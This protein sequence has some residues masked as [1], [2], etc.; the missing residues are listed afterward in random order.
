MINT[1]REGEP[2]VGETSKLV[3][4]LLPKGIDMITNSRENQIVLFGK[5]GT[6]IIYGFKY[7]QLGDKRQQGSW[8]KWKLNNNL[9]YHF[10]IDDDYFY[11]DS[12]NFLQKMSIVQAD[13]DISIDQDNVNYLL[14][15][16]NYTTVSGGSYNSSTKVTTFTNQSDW[17]DQVTAPNPV[18]NKLVIVD[19]NT[20]STRVGRYAEC[21]II[22]NDD[23]T[24][25]G[26]WSSATLNIGYLY[27]YYVKFPTIYSVKTEGNK[28]IADVNASLIIHRINLSFGKI[29]LYETTLT[30]VDRD[31][32]TE[33]YESPALNQYNISDAPYV[34][35][36]VK[37]VPVYEKNTNVDITLKSRHP[38]PTTLHSMSWEGDY[39]PLYYQRV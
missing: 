26:D 32:Y 7:F 39:S 37:T 31:D 11:L 4:S 30:R 16:D 8:F 12:D 18:V 14:H 21:T 19:S 25:P 29:G 22:N 13:A 38:A 35:E 6:N 28:S 36:V 9:K 1:A 5:T 3:P 2:T 33:V 10:I 17:I 27:E 20:N 24:V 15:L 34:A 23:F